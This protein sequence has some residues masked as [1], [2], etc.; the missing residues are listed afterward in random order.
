MNVK[1]LLRHARHLYN[2][3]HNRHAWVRSVLMLGDKWLLAQQ[4]GRIN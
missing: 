1:Q 4:V 2:S 3:K